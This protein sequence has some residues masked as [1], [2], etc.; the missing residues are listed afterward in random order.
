MALEIRWTDNALEDYKSIIHYLV[1]N[2]SQT[3]ARKFIDLAESRI[4][5]LALFPAIGI[6]SSKEPGVRS[7]VLTKKNKLYYR[8]NDSKLEILGIFD[9]RQNPGKNKFS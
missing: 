9:T 2:W 6:S 1:T 8:V 7:I 5:T 3:T 4:Q